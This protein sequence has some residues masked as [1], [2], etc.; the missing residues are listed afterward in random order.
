VTTFALDT[1]VVIAAIKGDA[2]VRKRFDK[3]RGKGNKIVVPSIVLFEL[4]YGIGKSSRAVS[5]EADLKDFLKIVGDVI[6]FS[7]TDAACAGR[8]RAMLDLAGT[9]I[10]PYDTLIA[11]QALNRGHTLVT[12]NTGEFE[13]VKGLLLINWQDRATP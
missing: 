9:P 3:A 7:D 13:R 4:E 8:I 6:A 5:A 12:R 10:G 2:K 11:G 1:N